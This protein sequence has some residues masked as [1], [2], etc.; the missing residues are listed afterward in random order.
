MIFKE[1]VDEIVLS[2]CKNFID[3]NENKI[4]DYQVFK[5]SLNLH[6]RLI[7]SL[8]A[9]HKDFDE[10]IKNAI[11]QQ[12]KYSSDVMMEKFIYDFNNKKI[13]L[14]LDREAH[15]YLIKLEKIEKKNKPNL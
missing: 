8:L 5:E 11:Q 9:S 12:K 13:S 15:L 1:K 2:E 14:V 6:G 3:N 10:A 7:D 4:K